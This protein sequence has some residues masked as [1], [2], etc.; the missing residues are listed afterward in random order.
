MTAPETGP[1]EAAAIA[2]LLSHLTTDGLTRTL[3][4]DGSEQTDF[5]L[6]VPFATV[7][8]TLAD[9]SEHQLILGSQDF[10]GQ[11]VYGL[12][13][14]E[15][16]PVPDGATAVPVA[17][18]SQDI[19]NGVDRPLQEWQG[20][21]DAPLDSAPGDIPSQDAPPVDT[22]AEGLPLPPAPEVPG[23]VPPPTSD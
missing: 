12:V 21:A 10:S 16:F 18:L 9:G 3:T 5:G 14:P 8:L 17:L 6:E 15:T 11:G 20:V 4:M 1:A 13:D 19:L 22:P 23:E 7:R 2:F